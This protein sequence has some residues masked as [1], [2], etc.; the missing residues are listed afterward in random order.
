MTPDEF[1][2]IRTE[3][4]MLT[5]AQ[6]ARVLD[7]KRGLRISEIERGAVPI[8]QRIEMIMLALDDGWRPPQWNE[9]IG[10]NRQ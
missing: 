4:L 6:L 10:E 9:W 7:F 2:Q 1:R 8:L 3:R 5:Q